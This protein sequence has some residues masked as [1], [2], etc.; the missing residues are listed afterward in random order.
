MKTQTIF[1]CVSHMVDEGV[2][3]RC[4]RRLRDRVHG[5]NDWRNGELRRP[6]WNRPAVAI[7]LAAQIVAGRALIRKSAQ[8]AAELKDLVC[9]PGGSTVEGVR[10]FE[11]RE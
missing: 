7:A 1:D 5:S 10:V 6:L 3:L 2:A 9:S 8:H 4:I 11:E